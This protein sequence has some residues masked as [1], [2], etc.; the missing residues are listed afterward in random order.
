MLP[1]TDKV[2]EIFFFSCEK[3]T[4]LQIVKIFTDTVAI[5][6]TVLWPGTIG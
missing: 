2:R 4:N 6:R 1:S 5:L 3:I